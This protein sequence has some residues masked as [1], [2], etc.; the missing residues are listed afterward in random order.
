M[1]FLNSIL[2]IW[3]QVKQAFQ[4]FRLI[5]FFDIL[6][7]TL[8][9]FYLLKLIRETRAIQLAKGLVFLGIGY[10]VILGLEMQASEFLLKRL[11]TDLILVLVILFQPEIRHALESFGR[12]SSSLPNLRIFGLRAEQQKLREQAQQTINAVC[13]AC[14]DMSAEKIGSLLVIERSTMLGDV[15]SSGTL[16]DA[17]L[18]SQLLENI[19]YPKS[20]LHDGAAVVREGRLYAAGCVL[21]LT[22]NTSLPGDLGTRHR[23]ALGMSE[24]SDALVVV[25]SEETGQISLAVKGELRRDLDGKMLYNSLTDA[26]LHLPGGQENNKR[27]RRLFQK[28]D[29]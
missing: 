27:K 8:I 12:S 25:T 28:K 3:E 19:F 17:A 24:Q 1:E 7:V 23:A 20:P 29:K 2:S 26:L 11:F 9:I 6:L 22:D 16:V 4:V 13:E 18:S 15:I 5:D 10:L 21:P 14:R